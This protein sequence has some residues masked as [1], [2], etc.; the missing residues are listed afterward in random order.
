MHAGVDLHVDGAAPARRPGSRGEGRDGLRGVERRRE[1]V[2]QRGVHRVEAALAQ[3]Q[4]RRIDAVLAEL[5]PFVDERNGEPLCAPA[6]AARATAG[7]PCP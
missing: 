5:D 4:N 7:P 3:E 1:P 2:G 6:S